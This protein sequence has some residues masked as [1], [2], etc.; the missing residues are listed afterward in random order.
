MCA[1]LQIS[2]L[3]KIATKVARFGKKNDSFSPEMTILGSKTERRAPYQNILTKVMCPF[4]PETSWQKRCALAPPVPDI[5]FKVMCPSA[6]P[7][8]RH[9]SQN[10]V[11]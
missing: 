11:P 2:A 7:R 5:L 8:T 1:K 4:T 9:P 10:D 3:D 6:R